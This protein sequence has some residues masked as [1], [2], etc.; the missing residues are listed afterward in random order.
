MIFHLQCTANGIIFGTYQAKRTGTDPGF[1]LGGAVSGNLG[2]GNPPAGSRGRAPV[3]S[4]GRSPKNV[5]SW[6]W[7]KPLS[8]WGEKTS[9]HTLTLYDNII[10]I[11]I[12][13]THRFV[14]S[15]FCLK[16]ENAV[17][18]LHS[19]RNGPLATVSGI[20]TINYSCAI[21]V[22][23]IRIGHRIRWRNNTGLIKRV[24]WKEGTLP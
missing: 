6:G 13:S 20:V 2:D 1:C 15:H 14:S 12:S 18:W 10:I 3:R 19:Q 4:G 5:T 9:P 22:S 11:I 23:L 24:S 16:I 17:C 7:K 21:C 8:L